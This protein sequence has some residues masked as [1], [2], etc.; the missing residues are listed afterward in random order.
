VDVTL[1]A[2][3][4]VG[5]A[6]FAHVVSVSALIDVANLHVSHTLEFTY[7]AEKNHDDTQLLPTPR[8]NGS[9]LTQKDDVCVRP[10][11]SHDRAHDAC[12]NM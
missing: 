2:R 12:L 7:E 4:D 6:G 3:T 5:M 1:C 11:V 9:Q 8:V 10:M